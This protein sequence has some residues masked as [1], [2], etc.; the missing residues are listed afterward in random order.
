[1]Q[2]IKT[3]IRSIICLAK[4]INLYEFISTDGTSLPDSEPGAH[5]G[6]HLPNEM[7]RHYSLLRA[8]KNPDSYQVAVKKDKNSSGGSVYIH[9]RLKVGDV[10]YIEPPQNSFPLRIDADRSIFFAGGIGITPIYSMVS[11]LKKIGRE[12]WTLYYACR[13]KQ[14]MAFYE[15]LKKFP[16]VIFHFDEEAGD[17]FDIYSAVRQAPRDAHLYCCGPTPMIEAF[18]KATADFPSEQIHIEYFKPI[19]TEADESFIVELARSGK[20]FNIGKG[21]TILR[22]LLEHGMDVP[23]SCEAGICGTCE[24]EV[25][26]GIPDHRDEVLSPA[27]KASNRKMTICCSRS[28]T[29]KLVL[30]L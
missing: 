30:N 22:V 2:L 4:D 27:E 1:M 29:P 9:E 6:I 24:T 8:E 11:Y 3:Q 15:E 20:S 7:V 25:L 18:R 23:F 10:L 26:E 5:I 14:E 17:V 28:K 13:N 19:V 16:Q 21:Q 12:D